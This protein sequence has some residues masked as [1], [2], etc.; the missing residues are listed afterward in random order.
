[1][2]IESFIKRCG[3][4]DL[5]LCRK[6]ATDILH[7][8]KW[9]RRYSISEIIEIEGNYKG[10]PRFT[11]D[12]CYFLNRHQRKRGLKIREYYVMNGKI[13]GSVHE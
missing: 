9:I 12:E 10:F 11:R 3:N 5:C 7:F 13:L 2:I 1:M 6:K 4:Y 8:K